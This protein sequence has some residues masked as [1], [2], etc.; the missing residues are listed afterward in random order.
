[1]A[2]GYCFGLNPSP[3]TTAASEGQKTQTLTCQGVN[4][5]Y[6]ILYSISMTL[7]CNFPGHVGTQIL[8]LFHPSILSLSSSYNLFINPPSFFP[9]FQDSTLFTFILLTILSFPFRHMYFTFYCMVSV[10]SLSYTHSY[11]L[12]SHFQQCD[13]ANSEFPLTALYTLEFSRAKW[14][15]LSQLGAYC[16]Y[17]TV[18]P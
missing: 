5:T 12:Q 4:R 10:V 14:N 7:V 16:S 9:S 6:I 11:S 8:P 13:P 17:F 1:M 18:E 2:F 15:N 3:Q